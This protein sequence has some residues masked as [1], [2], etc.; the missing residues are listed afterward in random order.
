MWAFWEPGTWGN[1]ATMNTGARE[2]ALFSSRRRDL[3]PLPPAALRRAVPT[4]PRA[5]GL[6][7]HAVKD[8][9]T[10]RAALDAIRGLG[11]E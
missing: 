7:L 8:G 4:G 2:I 1:T 9:R 3:V 6:L 10:F 5:I 11:Q